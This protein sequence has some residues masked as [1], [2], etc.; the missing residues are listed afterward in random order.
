MTRDFTKHF[1]ILDLAALGAIMMLVVEE[2]DL[3]TVFAAFVFWMLFR[4][5][6]IFASRDLK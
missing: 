6:L 5:I 3:S 2:A 1:P 4:G